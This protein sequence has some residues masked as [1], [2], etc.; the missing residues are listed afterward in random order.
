MGVSGGG[1]V[2]CTYDIRI[3]SQPGKYPHPYWG[4]SNV[5]CLRH[6]QCKGKRSGEINCW[7]ACTLPQNWHKLGV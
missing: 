3:S 6:I 4:F 2:L 1:V 5:E 7:K